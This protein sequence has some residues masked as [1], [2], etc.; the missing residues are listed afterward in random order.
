MNK[1][2]FSGL[3][4]LVVLGLLMLFLFRQEL[5]QV[6]IK[7]Q[8]ALAATGAT[9]LSETDEAAGLVSRAKAIAKVEPALKTTSQPLHLQSLRS[10]VQLLKK[11]SSANANLKGLYQ[12]LQR[13]KQ[14][15]EIS[16]SKNPYTG[17]L[18]MIR[19]KSP[20]PG[21]RYLHGQYFA[22]ASGAHFVQHLSFEF[23]P[24]PQA[25][26]EVK[27]MLLQE[28]SELQKPVRESDNMIVYRLNDSYNVWLKKLSRK[29]LE[30]SPFN[31]YGPEDIGTILVALELEVH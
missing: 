23:K 26:S 1:R 17:E 28:F 14:K 31:A 9:P 13:T 29:D 11:A 30:N 8:T 4:F 25:M 24:G 21:T 15:P 16:R 19:T 22:Q 20:L 2:I 18:V 12:E 3:T 5:S 27:T 6:S 7:A 10:M